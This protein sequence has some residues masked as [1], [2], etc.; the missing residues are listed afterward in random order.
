M[1]KEELVKLLQENIRLIEDIQSIIV[2]LRSSMS[3]GEKLKSIG[4]TIV[5]LPI[6]GEGGGRKDES[7][8]R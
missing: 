5:A 1:P 2:I 3:S 6:E 8:E 4:A 7:Q